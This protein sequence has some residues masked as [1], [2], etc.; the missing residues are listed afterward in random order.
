MKV[1][2]LAKSTEEARYTQVSLQEVK[3]EI[4]H[5]FNIN[6][7]P[8]LIFLDICCKISNTRDHENEG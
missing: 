3:L 1:R 8:N 4:P 5:K 7:S 2:K 6:I